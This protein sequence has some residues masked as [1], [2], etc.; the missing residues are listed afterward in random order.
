MM[1]Q[2]SRPEKIKN[3][4]SSIQAATVASTLRSWSSR[5]ANTRALRR[6]QR[7]ASPLDLGP[8]CLGIAF[9]ITNVRMGGKMN[10][11]VPFSFGRMSYGMDHE[12]VR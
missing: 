6:F 4:P 11:F 2:S 12:I 8:R 10:A 1:P 3:M 7:H 9:E 5:A